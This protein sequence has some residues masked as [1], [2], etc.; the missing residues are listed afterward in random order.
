MIDLLKNGEGFRETKCVLPFLDTVIFFLLS[1]IPAGK[2]ADFCFNTWSLFSCSSLLTP[3]L[4]KVLDFILGF[5]V[6]FAPPFCSFRMNIDDAFWAAVVSVLATT[7]SRVT[8]FIVSVVLFQ[9]IKRGYTV[10]TELEHSQ[11]PI[12]FY[13][14]TVGE[15]NPAG[16]NY[17]RSDV[18]Y[19]NTQSL[20]YFLY[21]YP[22]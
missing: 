20:K 16:L 12:R 21:F 1:E 9:F 17:S 13:N 14:T 10:H 11:S 2:V 15:S 3:F 18:R 4:L 8:V 6:P 5:R 22:S 7:P 19:T